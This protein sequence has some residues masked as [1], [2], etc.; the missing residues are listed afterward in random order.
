MNEILFNALGALAYGGVGIVILV[1]GY[2]LTDLLTP[3]KL[4]VL[5]WENRNRNAVLLVSANTLGSAIIVTSAILSSESEI[6]L[7]AGL[8]STAVYGLIGLGVMALSFVLIDLL[9]PAKIA[10][11]IS[12]DEPHPATWV[13]ASAH[14]AIAVVIAAALT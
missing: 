1:L 4:H 7:G 13:S 9:V 5:I 11:M 8:L 2:L 12:N 6:G 14:V 10:Q 3:G